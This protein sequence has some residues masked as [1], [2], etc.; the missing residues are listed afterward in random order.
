MDIPKQNFAIGIA[1]WLI[2]VLLI[3]PNALL[4]ELLLLL[5]AVAALFFFP[6]CARHICDAAQTL[7]P[8][9]DGTSGTL[10]ISNAGHR[11]NPN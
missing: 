6:R 5:A 1:G 10:R 2:R 7:P 8:R 9:S 4:V 11:P 3:L